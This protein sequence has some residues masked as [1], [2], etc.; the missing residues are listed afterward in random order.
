[1]PKSKKT[2][3]KSRTLILGHLEGISST[4]FKDFPK[5]LTDLVGR[6]HGVYALYKGNRLYYVGLATNLRNRIKYHLRDRHAGR[7]D[8]F[9]LYLVRKADHIKELESLIMRIANPAGNSARGRLPKADNLIKLL[10]K[11]IADEQMRQRSDLFGREKKKTA[12]KKPVR[13]TRRRTAT[14]RQAPSLAP[15][16]KKAFRIRGTY[17]GKSYHASVHKG[18]VI[19]FNNTLYNSPSMAGQAARRRSTNGW[20]FWR[21]KNSKGEWVKLDELRK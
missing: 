20:T 1:M 3:R 18:G 10:E 8:K 7:W 21:F 9:S 4:I 13:R 12:R 2:G 14:L 11:T 19:K 5:Q 15:Y 17:K 6:Q 16:A